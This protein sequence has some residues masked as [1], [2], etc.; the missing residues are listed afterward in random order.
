M[1]GSQGCA[2]VEGAV[3]GRAAKGV[4]GYCEARP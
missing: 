3:K 4:V 2:D 1:C